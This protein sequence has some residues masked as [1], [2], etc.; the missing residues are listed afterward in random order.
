M[1]RLIRERAG[2]EKFSRRGNRLKPGKGN[3]ATQ[4]PAALP[5]FFPPPFV[6]TLFSFCSIHRRHRLQKHTRLKFT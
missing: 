4:K 2:D 1:G 6:S 3:F 5:L